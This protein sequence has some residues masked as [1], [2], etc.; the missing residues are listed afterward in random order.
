MNERFWV[1]YGALSNVEYE[2]TVTDTLTGNV[3]TYSNPSG[4][5]ASVGDTEGFP[6]GYS[7][8]VQLDQSRSASKLIPTEGGTLSATAA[9]GTVFTLTVPA[10]ALWSDEEITMTPV[11]A[12]DRLPLSGGLVAAVQLAPEGL[13]LFE[14]AT[15]TINPPAPIPIDEEITFAWRGSGEEFFL[16]P[17]DPLDTPA[18]SL[19]LMHFSGYGGG[20]GT[21]ADQAAQGRRPPA[22][23]GDRLKQKLQG[24][25]KK[26]RQSQRRGQ[27]PDPQ[28]RKEAQDI[29]NDDLLAPLVEPTC[30]NWEGLF[31]SVALRF[32]HWQASGLDTSPILDDRDKIL[33]V[34]VKCY[35]E[36][37]GRCKSDKD[38]SQGKE[39]LRI[40]GALKSFGGQNRVDYGKIPKCLSFELDFESTVEDVLEAG[41]KT[42]VVHKVFANTVPLEWSESKGL[43]GSGTLNYIEE[44]IGFPGVPPCMLVVT[45]KGSTFAV[46][47]GDIDFNIFEG[48]ARPPQ[49]LTM[50]IDPGYPTATWELC[51]DVPPIGRVCVTVPFSGPAWRAEFTNL[52]PLPEMTAECCW[53]IKD[54]IINPHGFYAV[55][56]YEG[57]KVNIGTFTITEKKTCLTLLHKPK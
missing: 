41:I 49:P 30:S 12:I 5:F 33:A 35:D 8:V 42:T 52:H 9:D 45:A 4:R 43:T 13:L 11:A 54:W 3:N 23:R 1:F 56:C 21:S 39:M 22:N 36:A 25:A 17:P 29:L 7:V 34:A 27:G 47:K 2:M 18:I 55:K 24:P 31:Q 38:P 20:K 48:N 50:L 10:G 37:Y 51:C 26:N 46:L 16:Y 19:S 57:K 44:V 40:Y 28:A 15:L 53:E 14:P 32:V 6:S